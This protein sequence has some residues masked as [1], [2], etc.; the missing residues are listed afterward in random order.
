MIALVVEPKNRT[1]IPGKKWIKQKATS[2][3]A[4]CVITIKEIHRHVFAETLFYARKRKRSY[5]KRIQ[6][7][8]QSGDDKKKGHPGGTPRF[9]GCLP[10]MKMS[11]SKST[12]TSTSTTVMVLDGIAAENSMRRAV[13]KRKQQQ[14]PPGAAA[15]L[16]AAAAAAAAATGPKKIATATRT[17]MMTNNGR[18][19]FVQEPKRRKGTL[20]LDHKLRCALFYASSDNDYDY[21]NVDDDDDEANHD[22]MTNDHEILARL[23]RKQHD[24]AHWMRMYRK[25]E[26]Y[27]QR[28]DTTSIPY[29]SRKHALLHR[30]AHLQRT[31]RHD[32]EARVFLLKKIGFVW[33]PRKDDDWRKMYDRLVLYKA[34]HGTAAVPYTSKTHPQLGY[35]VRYQRRSCWCMRR[36]DLLN[37][38]G[39]VWWPK[40][41]GHLKGNKRP[42]KLPPPNSSSTTNNK[43]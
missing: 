29:S 36:V 20:I 22:A 2:E 6:T 8:I 40:W 28:H 41:G 15:L 43:P 23:K 31:V 16:A 9:R 3:T 24:D 10:W 12:S 25:L 14:Q 33:S 21:V 27:K 35:W 30:W 17:T 32:N 7:S 5:S 1:S 42:R 13:S 39:F 26:A 34:V 18:P 38:I 37:K 19:A 4:K 11:S